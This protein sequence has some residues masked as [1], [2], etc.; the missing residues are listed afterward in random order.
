MSPERSVTYVS[1]RTK[2]LRDSP[3][4]LPV[5]SQSAFGKRPEGSCFSRMMVKNL[6]PARFFFSPLS[7][8]FDPPRAENRKLASLLLRTYDPG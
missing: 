8:R 5:R 6:R 1:E 2:R 7:F 3:H 4:E